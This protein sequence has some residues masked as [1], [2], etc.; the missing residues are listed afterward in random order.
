MNCGYCSLDETKIIR[1][2]AD[3]CDKTF[4]KED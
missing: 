2:I 1:C 3:I 4:E